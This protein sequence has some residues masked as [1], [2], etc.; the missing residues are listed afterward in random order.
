MRSPDR[1][2]GLVEKTTRWIAAIALLAVASLPEQQ[3]PIFK[4]L[5]FD[6]PGS[7]DLISEPPP[8][9]GDIEKNWQV[10]ELKIKEA[11]E[12][13][14]SVIG[15][16]KIVP[17]NIAF[18]DSGYSAAAMPE[19][20]REIPITNTLLLNHPPEEYYDHGLAM[21][22]LSVGAMW[23]NEAGIDPIC[24]AELCNFLIENA[25]SGKTYDNPTGFFVFN[26]SDLVAA[27]NWLATLTDENGEPQISVINMSWGGWSDVTSLRKAV[28]LAHEK[29][30]LLVAGT[31]NEG[32]ENRCF[33]PA[34][35]PDVISVRAVLHLEDDPANWGED[36]AIAS[37]SNS[38][39]DKKGV[40]APG[41]LINAPQTN[42]EGVTTL[43]WI[44]G[45][46]PATTEVT[47]MLGMLITF[48]QTM[49]IDK[50]EA[51]L[52]AEEAL[53][54]SAIIPIYVEETQIVKWGLGMPD[55]EKAVAY[56]MKKYG[57]T[58]PIPTYVLYLPMIKNALT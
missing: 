5:G 44:A 23:D 57:Y 55:Q 21:A 22:A 14:Q 25:A 17:A 33:F 16:R 32:E 10:R 37:F 30:I 7:A 12:L 50:I 9:D 46:S 24:A 58:V 31:G 35:Y 42:A 45:T 8:L 47:G 53:L 52:S 1:K 13:I 27:L 38:C 6:M 49:G 2:I 36:L 39:D 11:W 29:G 15:D 40:A 43:E 41:S 19:D 18:I 3:K 34:K 51:G 54:A 28:E 20:L 4:S 26:Y 56:L 48:L